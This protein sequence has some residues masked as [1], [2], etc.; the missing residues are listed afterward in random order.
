MWE[1]KLI[2]T[3]S[4]RKAEKELKKASEDGWELVEFRT[5][6]NWLVYHYVFLLR[7]ARK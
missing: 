1:Y 6:G 2:D 7:R 4:D 5:G 3:G